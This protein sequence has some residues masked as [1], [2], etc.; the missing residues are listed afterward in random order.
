[1]LTQTVANLGRRIERMETQDRPSGGTAGGTAAFNDAEGDP[2]NVTTAAS[3]G[4]STYPSR[5]DHV[6]T[7]AN[8]T[9][10]NAML[11]NM[12]GTTIKG[13]PSGAAGDPTDLTAAQV[14]TIL[15]TADGAGSLLDADTLDG[16]H[17]TAFATASHT[18]EAGTGSYLPLGGGN[19]SGPIFM[20]SAGVFDVGT[21]T[22]A[23]ATSHL[24][25]FGTATY[26]GTVNVYAPL[27]VVGY[28]LT[29]QDGISAGTITGTRVSA[30]TVAARTSS[31]LR[32]QDDGGN[33]GMF[34]EDG[35]NVGIGTANPDQAL[36]VAANARVDGLVL[37]QKYR[38][39]ANTSLVE[40][41]YEILTAAGLGLIYCANTTDGQHFI[42]FFSS[43]GVVEIADSASTWAQA[44]TAGSNCLYWSAGNGLVLKNYRTGTKN[45]VYHI[46]GST[47]V[48]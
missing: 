3:D 18:H 29:A 17:A 15:L 38:A 21:I 13:R 27:N 33:L 39:I 35:G 4:A 43:G 28:E 20:G 6:H 31:G 12:A 5:R 30:G 26:E 11:A 23:A 36:H 37:A 46:L 2:A 40:G 22:S 19:M 42:G 34:V 7:I 9:V 16:Q 48:A 25:W 10:S 8:D 47:G 1:M 44:D 14:I 32:L 45:Y 41:G 24:R